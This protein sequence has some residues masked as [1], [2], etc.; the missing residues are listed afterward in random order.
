MN[1]PL[2]ALSR[3]KKIVEKKNTLYMDIRDV[4]SFFTNVLLEETITF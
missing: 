3:A 1:S 4:D 2:K